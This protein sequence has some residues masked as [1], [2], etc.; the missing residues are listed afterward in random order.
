MGLL[1]DLK[2]QA[3]ARLQQ[4]PSVQVT[5]LDI[6][7]HWQQVHQ[8]LTEASRYL[9]E[10]AQS[11][12]VVK[13][14]VRRQYYLEGSAKLSNLQQRDYLVRDHR[15]TIGGNDYLIDVSLHCTCVGNESLTFEKETR[16]ANMIKEYLWAYSLPFDNRDIRDDYG[17]IIRSVITVMGRVPSSVTLAGNWDTGEYELKLRNV[18]MLGEVKQAFDAEDINRDFFEEIGKLVLGQPNQLRSF[19]KRARAPLPASFSR[20]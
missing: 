9:S 6:H 17:R 20:P 3:D 7:P 8:S 19:G 13:P 4:V 12:N 1:D 18:E 16:Q 10:L 11:L 5:E 2:K 15:K 14:D